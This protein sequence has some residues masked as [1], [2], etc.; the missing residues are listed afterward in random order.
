MRD[1]DK[2]K[3]QLVSELAA[4][5]Q[6]VS[7][8]EASETGRGGAGDTPGLSE[9]WYRRII[10][11]AYEGVWVI[12][13]EGKT[14]YANRRMAEM[15]GCTT[16]EMIGR[17]AFDFVYEADLAD[18]ERKLERRKR[19]IGELAEVRQRRKDGSELWVLSSTSPIQDESGEIIGVLGMMTDI[20]E[21]KRA[22]E[23]IHFQ[24]Q[25]LDAV[26]QAVIATDVE[27][28]IVFWNRFAETLYGWSAEEVMGRPVTDVVM[29]EDQQERADE[30]MSEL[31]ADRSWSGEFVVRRRDGTTFPAMVTDAPVYDERGNLT[32]IIGISTDITERKRAEEERERLLASEQET[33]ERASNIL[34]SI[35]DAFFAV[36]REWR[37]T[38]I[39]ERALRR[40][41]RAKGEEITCEELL[42]KNVWELFPEHMDTVF[43]Q[44]Y[45]EAL[46]EQKTVYFEGYSSATDTW[47]EVYV[48]PSEEGLA[49]YSRDI[50]ERK[51]AEKE[52]ETRTRQQAIVAELGYRAL[53][54][55]DLQALM[56]EAVTLVAET[57]EI[58]YSKVVELL[59]EGDELLLRAGVGWKEGLVGRATEKTGVGSQAGFT[60]LSEEPVVVEDFGEE[61]RFSASA[62]LREHGV[63]SG[64]SVIIQGRER[65]FGILGAHTKELW[66]FT[67]DD[68]NFLQAIANALAAAIER[69]RDE[70]E[71]AKRMETLGEQARLLDLAHDAITVRDMNGT[72]AFWNRGAEDTYGWSREE[73]VGEN[74]HSLLKTRFPEPLE[75]IE[76][77]LL[78]EGRWE[79]ELVHTKHDGAQVM[80]ASRWALERDD[81]GQ[82]SAILE[83]NN[84]ITEHKQLE[85]REHEARHQLHTALKALRES[86]ARFKRLAEVNVIGIGVADLS[87]NILE[88]NEAFL[89]TVGYTQED[90]LWGDL[91][92]DEITPQE[93]RP[94]D[95]RAVEQ[96]ERSGVCIPYEKEFIRKDGSHIPVLVGAVL[97]AEGQDSAIV[98]IL[99]LTGHGRDG[100][101]SPDDQESRDPYEKAR[102]DLVA[103]LQAMQ[104]GQMELADVDPDADSSQRLLSK[105]LND[106]RLADRRLRGVVSDLHTKHLDRGRPFIREAQSLAQ[107]RT[108][109]E[110]VE[111]LVELNRQIASGREIQLT[112]EDGFPSELPALTRLDLLGILK[113]ALANARRH[114]EARCI[115]VTLGCEG[116][117]YWVEVTDDG[118][119]FET[120]VRQEGMGMPGMREGARALGGELEVKC[121]PG[122]GTRVRVTF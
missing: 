79:G 22:E 48:Y 33:R 77:E 106:L 44:K 118:Q 84:D 39:N 2:T 73:A 32:G 51:R 116:D 15:L 100:E 11:A 61:E 46:R 108:F 104:D 45:H 56:N 16:E 117:G 24:A 57:L 121:E 49:V 92:V 95:E 55:M 9:G 27:G 70:E 37:Y 103:A 74:C 63:T 81:H 40:V 58:E 99:D 25:L 97:S 115:R 52:L 36:D 78:H 19:G 8:L 21:R 10:D 50:T 75:E 90:L 93:Y 107:D 4:L 87:G 101:I 69:K 114:S 17:S 31:K 109:L 53:S 120:K 26:G 71:L 42:G 29:S 83:I 111:S 86:E 38:Y 54:G 3:D 105:E 96:L 88:A 122:K 12:D 85:L 113:E 18:A 102:E 43:G 112:V 98:L 89:Q 64:I 110:E 1:K 80:V 67:K 34:E 91:H 65:P 5:R 47:Y 68:I 60:L 35:S 20:T 13:T 14:E 6:K 72:I 66:T 41:Q 7:E 82:P 76:A 30:I 94:L 119:G 28:N 59:S 62:L 23:R